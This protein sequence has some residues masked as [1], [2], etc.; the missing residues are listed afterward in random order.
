MV[1]AEL[2]LQ[3]M[4]GTYGSGGTIDQFPDASLSTSHLAFVWDPIGL[5]A[6]LEALCYYHSK[7]S[8]QQVWPFPS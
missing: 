1:S 7:L 6:M 8:C 3:A 5:K 4:L 2:V